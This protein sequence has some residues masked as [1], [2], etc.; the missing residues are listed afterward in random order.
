MAQEHPSFFGSKVRFVALVL[1]LVL[2]AAAGFA[3]ERQQPTPEQ[4]QAYLRTLRSHPDQHVLTPDRKSARK[5]PYRGT[6]NYGKRIAV[7]G[8]SLSVNAESDAAKQIWADQLNAEVTTYGVGGAGFSS[9][10]GY[11]LQRQVD[12]AGVYDVYVLWASTNDYTNSRECG[13]WKDYTEYDGF[14]ASKLITQCGGINYCIRKLMEK[15]PSAE[16]Y[17]FTSLRFFGQDAGHNPFSDTPNKTGKTFADYIEAQKACCAH[18][19]VP[20]LDQFNLQGINAFNCNLY[21][22]EDRLHMNEEGYRKIGPVQAAFLS[23]G[24]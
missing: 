7:F 1:A 9:E 14:D 17:F 5:S 24:R 2:P 19:G 3:Q 16:I 22:L 6:K 8:G 23:N 20:V 18:Y 4:I 12:T 11:S 21:Y 15:N 13:T 10:Q